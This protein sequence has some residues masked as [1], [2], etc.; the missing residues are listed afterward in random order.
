MTSNNNLNLKSQNATIERWE[1]LKSQNV[2]IESRHRQHRKHLPYAFT[3]KQWIEKSQ[4]NV[5]QISSQALLQSEE[6]FGQQAVAQLVQIP[7]GTE[8]HQKSAG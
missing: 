3:P 7:W 4:Q 1:S 8:Y 5:D 2:T 6:S